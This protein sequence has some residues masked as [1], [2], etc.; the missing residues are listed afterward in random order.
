TGVSIVGMEATVYPNGLKSAPRGASEQE[1]Q[2]NQLSTSGSIDMNSD[3]VQ[4]AKVSGVDQ[5]RT[6][7]HGETGGRNTELLSTACQPSS[8][9][10]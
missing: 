9:S 1:V 10:R 3:A 8:R 6:V 4:A 7:A 5:S 2:G